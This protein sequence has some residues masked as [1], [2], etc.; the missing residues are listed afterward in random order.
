MVGI[1][2]RVHNARAVHTFSA[3]GAG[4]VSVTLCKNNVFSA[5]R[6]ALGAVVAALFCASSAT[7]DMAALSSSSA[8][9]T[10]AH[11]GTWLDTH[12]WIE[13]TARDRYHDRFAIQVDTGSTSWDG[14]D[15]GTD[16]LVFATTMDIPQDD[17]PTASMT[18]S[19]LLGD[20]SSV[21]SVSDIDGNTTQ[22]F[23]GKSLP[24]GT[25]PMPGFGSESLGFTAAAAPVP[26]ALVLAALGLAA[27]AAIRRRQKPLA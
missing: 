17:T 27:V 22:R 14:G 13:A 7:A 16:S 1:A 9:R 5:T 25:T 24:L 2:R 18:V 26:G 21:A 11:A 12:K 15:W 3:L 8:I 6:V 4:M 23:G 10:G 20:G 19:S